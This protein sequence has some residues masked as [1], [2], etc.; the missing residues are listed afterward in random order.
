[1]KLSPELTRKVL[2][3]ADEPAPPITEK[4]FQAEVIRLAKRNG[5]RCFHP[6]DSRRSKSGWPD[7]AMVHRS[8]GFVL[9]ELKTADGRLS[10]A[11]EEWLADL[12]EAGVRVYLWRPQ[13]FEEI[14]SV[15]SGQIR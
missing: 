13:D 14:G 12:R 3:L 10:D 1:M 9:A 7:L 6:Y 5:W 4:A 15:L 11:Q 2:E 8:Y